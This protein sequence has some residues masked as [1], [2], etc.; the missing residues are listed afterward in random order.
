MGAK[1]LALLLLTLTP[2]LGFSLKVEVFVKQRGEIFKV[3]KNDGSVLKE[4]L[5]LRWENMPLFTQ[6]EVKKKGD[7]LLIL[8]RGK[9]KGCLLVTN[10][11]DFIKLTDKV[12]QIKTD[13]GVKL[14]QVFP[15]GEGERPGLPASVLLE[16]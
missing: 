3:V 4:K 9:L 10:R 2:L 13:G 15:L 16:G 6:F 5:N 14:I 7:S 11:G 1:V 8:W 12:F